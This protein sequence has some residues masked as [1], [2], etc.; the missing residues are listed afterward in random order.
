MQLASKRGRESR[1][2]G[3]GRWKRSPFSTFPT[4]QATSLNPKS[5]P[6]LNSP[7]SIS[8]NFDQDLDPDSFFATGETR[9][10]TKGN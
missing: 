8:P 4:T 1:D 9:I 6:N 3:F 2:S 7:S 10:P 5:S